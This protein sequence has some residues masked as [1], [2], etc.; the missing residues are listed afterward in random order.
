MRRRVELLCALCMMGPRTG[1][2]RE[3][4]FS[5]LP[6]ALGRLWMKDSSQPNNSSTVKS[7]ELQSSLM[8]CST[9]KK[10]AR[11]CESSPWL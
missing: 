7:T 11:Q 2:F 8:F 1:A 3:Q 4:R 5:E 10:P 9:S 6:G